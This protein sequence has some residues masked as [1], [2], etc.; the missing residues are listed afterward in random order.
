MST[1]KIAVIGDKDSIL[2]FKTLGVDTFPVATAEKALSVL[3][4]LSNQT[5]G[6]IFITEE[7]AQQLEDPLEELN[8]RFLPAVV[9]IPNS[10]G[11]LGIG[12]QNI[13]QKVEKAIGA[14]ILFR[15]EG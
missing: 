10:Q 7:L 13:K 11:T 3:R 2:G 14:D 8:K 6:V 5:Y 15:K 1:Y 12:M 4:K 9:L